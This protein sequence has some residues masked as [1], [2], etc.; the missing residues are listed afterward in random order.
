VAAYLAPN[1]HYS[2][3]SPGLTAAVDNPPLHAIA[4]TTSANGVYLYDSSA[5]FPTQTF[6]AT[7]YF[8]DVVFA[9]AGAPGQVTNVQA[10]PDAGA[11]N[12][13]WTAP[14]GSDPVTQY[15]VTP[16]VGTTAQAATTVTG[17]PPMTNARIHNLTGGTTY[18][19]KVTAS[20]PNGSGQ[21]SDPSNAVTP[22][23]GSTASAP[24]N[25]VAVPGSQSAQVSWAAPANNGGSP[26][27]G[28]IVTPYV[29][30]T[31]GTP[32]TV[33]ASALSATVN[34]LTNSTTYTFKVAATTAAGTGATSIS[35][36]AVTPQKTIFDWTVPGTLD[37]GDDSAVELGVKFKSDVAGS[38]TGI[39]FHK[40]AA[41][42][43]AHVGALWTA[44]GALLASATFTNET[45]SGW[46]EVD[47]T[48]PVAIT[49][50]TTYVA[51]YFAPNGHY[52]VGTGLGSA[53]DNPPLHTIPNATSP[54]GV[55][56]YVF[57]S[58][59]PTSSFNASNYLVDVMF[60]AG[61]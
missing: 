44:S 33:G 39:R 49:A 4:N 31:A 38:V 28:Y 9:A 5:S 22:T 56:S 45:V 26:V 11:A 14:T 25:V 46:Q 41:N 13:T 40:A 19:F 29:D 35:S 36:N 52:S 18:T 16:Y 37:A 27:T 20:N 2:D 1:G 58:T 54:N 47:F 10:T 23:S 32:T 42:T 55:Y 30:S 43:G 17:S 51:G 60:R 34:G 3:T 59:F 24:Q 8:V 15:T 53:V 48:S 6:N 7:N 50:G 12:V 21:A 57:V 61:S